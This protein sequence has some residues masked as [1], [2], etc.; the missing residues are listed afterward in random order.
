MGQPQYSRFDIEHQP[1]VGH[2]FNRIIGYFDK[3][4]FLKF[5]LFMAA[6]NGGSFLLCLVVQQK[7]V[8]LFT[9]AG[10]FLK[11][12][13]TMVKCGAWISAICICTQVT[14]EALKVTV[15]PLFIVDIRKKFY[16]ALMNADIGLF[17]QMSTGLMISRIS[18][19]V[20][21]IGDIYV[22]QLFK[23]I[24]AGTLILGGFVV[25][26][27][28]KWDY[29]LEFVCFPVA[30][31][32]VMI[33]GNQYADKKYNEFKN[34]S[35][36]AID[37]ATAVITEFRTVKAFDQETSEAE[38]Y[39]TAL[40][41][42]ERIQAKVALI[43]ACFKAL[44]LIIMLTDML[45]FNWYLFKELT[46]KMHVGFFPM[47]V[48]ITG[49]MAMI[50]GVYFGTN[51]SDDFQNAKEA[52]IAICKVIEMKPEID[53]NHGRDIGTLHGNIEFRD[54]GFKYD[55]CDNWALRH[56]NLKLESGKTYAFVGESGCGKSTTLQLLQRFYDVA[57][58]AIL[59]DG[60]DIR[61]MT[62]RS[63]RRNISIV[64]QSPVL[65][66]MSIADNI[67][68]GKMDATE[69]Q[70]AQAAMT[71]NAHNFIMEL[72]DNYKTMVEQ[73]SLSGGQKQRICISRAILAP[74][75][76]LLLDEAT[77]ALDTESEQLVQQS[78]ERFK[79]GKTTIMVA[80][81]LSTV[82]NCDTIFVYQDGHV[83]EQG[84]HKELLAKGGIYANLAKFQ[85]E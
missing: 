43:R 32:F 20:S 28:Y 69:K 53:P 5:V 1:P 7:G 13:I 22:D 63:L 74:T 3:K 30:L 70:V 81:R 47:T 38:A 75:P 16:W 51:V 55:L 80:H 57:E 31:A 14:A 26:M 25:A 48:V 76:I 85:L 33:F 37:K 54:V 15:A 24:S 21:Y 23:Y 58:G 10:E 73:T 71:G 62:P 78:L 83:V 4:A 44:A 18:E 45:T 79:N 34:A 65:F 67:K 42:E 11:E 46:V 68:Y 41:E 36:D 40:A 6:L 17:D 9:N 2:E 56:L 64:P 72:P 29:T 27:C 49:N 52:S 77:A 61:E 39:R 50:Y 82:V 19:G 35:S 8:K 59:I 12:T 66:T 60:I 84:K